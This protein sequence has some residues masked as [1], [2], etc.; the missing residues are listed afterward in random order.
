MRSPVRAD[1]PGGLRPDIQGLRA[2]AVLAVVADHVLG[3]P[4][5]GYA[6]VDVFFVVSGFLITGL[7]LREHRRSGRVSVADF[8]R[9]RARRVLPVAV[10]VL[11]VTVLATYLLFNPARGRTV[12]VD[13]L[14]SLL[15][16]GNWHFAVIGTDYWQLDATSPVQHFW[17]L[18]VEEQFYVVWPCLLVAVLAAGRGRLRLLAAVVATIALASF[19]YSLWHTAAHPTWAYFSTLDRA[20]ELAVGALV[21]VG[22]GPA[23]RL[24][25]AARMCLGWAGLAGVLTGMLVLSPGSAFPAPGA[26]L[27]VLATAAVLVAGCGGP[28]RWLVPLVNPVARYVGD[29]SYS[30]YL[31]HFAV[32]ISAKAF[33]PA[34]GPEYVVW[35]LGLTA[36][37]SILSFHLVEDPVRSS[38]WLE[39][40]SRRPE[41][42]RAGRSQPAAHRFARPAAGAATVLAVMAASLVV[43]RWLGPV[44]DGLAA[45][46]PLPRSG[47]GE[48]SPALAARERG[49][50]DAVV[51]ADF[52]ELE[53][54]LDE[55]GVLRWKDELV[56][57]FGCYEVSPAFLD[58][59]VSGDR[60]AD[61]SAVLLGD[62]VAMAYL[63]GVVAALTPKGYR[64]QQL[65]AGQCPAW[66]VQV[67]YNGGSVATGCDRFHRWSERV[68][69]RQR[70]DL[71]VLVSA[72]LTAERL[73][74]GAT[75][76]A[77]AAEIEDGLVRR[78][79]ALRGAAGRVVV[80]QPA[81]QTATPLG[82]CVTRVGRPQDCT[83]HVG[84]GF[85][86]VERA[87]RAAAA[88][89]GASF[90]GTRHWYCD[91]AGACPGFVGRTPVRVDR[92]HLTME[93]SE[94]LAPL[95]RAELLD[96]SGR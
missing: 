5:G 57:R 92:T 43:V 34:G 48:V 93:Y 68:V 42:R 91:S 33:F 75:G 64:V 45:A 28:Q 24:P 87:E 52:P 3:R 11:A 32:V 58:R 88:R 16:A 54:G 71:V 62:S 90:V 77:A 89:T 72:Y 94:Q 81:P 83:V 17:S 85:L 49:I 73:S 6:G 18:A 10:L 4:S 31:W 63:P 2:L 84:T 22:A 25:A 80:L 70:P 13:A 53:P 50:R 46:A 35:A 86:R 19:G 78:I 15:F 96:G 38:A 47:P 44:D 1:R 27:P 23:S 95:L 67:L 65:T 21:A 29:I 20:W 74:S 51:A 76:E 39:P 7:L 55:L 26:A 82:E 59:C 40:R 69:A 56:R 30:L 79:R 36:V 12:A 61:R 60:D 14:W 37:L 8:Y 66:D 9:R 41:R